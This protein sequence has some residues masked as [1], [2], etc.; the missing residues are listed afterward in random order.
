MLYKI[1]YSERI[2]CGPEMQQGWVMKEMRENSGLEVIQTEI[3][4]RPK[5]R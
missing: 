5:T 4:G 2:Y 1:L 3:F